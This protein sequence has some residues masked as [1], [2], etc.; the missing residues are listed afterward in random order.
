[1]QVTDARGGTPTSDW[2]SR[3]SSTAFTSG[4][5]SI[6]ASNATYTPGPG[7]LVLGNGTLTPGASGSLAAQRI[8]MS[9]TGGTGSSQATWDPT[10]AVSIP[11]AADLG[12][13]TGTLTHSVS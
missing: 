8:A 7:T 13:Y 1:M 5:D 4:P 10:V 6:P 11:L 9:Y 12:T 2:I 3:V